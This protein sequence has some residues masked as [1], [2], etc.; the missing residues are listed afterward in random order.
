MPPCTVHSFILLLALFVRLPN[1]QI[2]QRLRPAAF[3]SENRLGHIIEKLGR[4]DLRKPGKEQP[5]GNRF[6]LV[7]LGLPVGLDDPKQRLAEVQK[8]MNALKRSPQAVVVLGLLAAVGSIPADMQ[9][10][11]VDLFGSK[12]TAVVSNVPG[13][14]EPLAMAGQAIDSLMFWVPQSGRLGLGISVL[15]YGGRVKFGVAADASLKVDAQGLA[16]DIEAALQE[17]IQAL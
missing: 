7:F 14:R 17:L 3:S 12:G 11:I 15:S 16:H 4:L 2:K 5:L 10:H 9:Q 1:Q 13:P 8:R 6:G